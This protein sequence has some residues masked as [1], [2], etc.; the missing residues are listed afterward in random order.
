MS[1]KH[2]G[3][4]MV[5]GCFVFGARPFN[6]DDVGVV[7]SGGYE[8]EAGY[9]FWKEQSM[10]GFGL[11]HGI[12]DKMDIGIGFGFNTFS[13]P[14]NSFTPSELILKWAIVPEL[15]AT[16][17]CANVGSSS[18]HLNSIITR[19]FGPIEIDANL[20]LIADDKSIT[21]ACALIY[22]HGRFALGG[23]IGGDKELQSWLIGGRY[24][25]IEGF[26]IDIGFCSNFK[27]EDKFMTAG[28]HYEF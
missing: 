7:E 1:L 11:K 10:F 9:D 3:Y 19:C 8:L 27:F 28:L 23:E 26:A 25:V 13:E 4:L 20:G 18:Y 16:S 6:T 15:F 24:E 2:I 17:F 22:K 12:T 14:E 5:I 21:Y